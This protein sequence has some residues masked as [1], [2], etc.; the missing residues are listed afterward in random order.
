MPVSTAG[1]GGGA[2]V[3]LAK[4]VER[5]EAKEGEEGER[6]PLQPPVVRMACGNDAAAIAV[7]VVDGVLV[8][9]ETGEEEDKDKDTDTGEEEERRGEGCGDRYGRRWEGWIGR[10]RRI[11]RSWNGNEGEEEEAVAWT[12]DVPRDGFGW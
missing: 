2:F 10:G 3:T 1:G 7:V 6:E 8:V 5:G 9:T 11:L 4:D 12:R